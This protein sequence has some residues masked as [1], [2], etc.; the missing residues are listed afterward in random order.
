MKCSA[1]HF[2]SF[3]GHNFNDLISPLSSGQ[4]LLLCFYGLTQ[5]GCLRQVFE[6]NGKNY[7][8]F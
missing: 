2:A 1:F 8:K 7:V 3:I 4:I 5:L 6:M